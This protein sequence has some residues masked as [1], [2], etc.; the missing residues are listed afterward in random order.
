MATAQRHGA[1]FWGKHVKA[2]A[3]SG[4]G[5]T[6]YCAAQWLN[7][8]SFRCWARR[9]KGKDSLAALTLV[10]VSLQGPLGAPTVR[11]RSPGGWQI[12]L[13]WEDAA[14]LAWLRRQLP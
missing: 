12:E 5:P 6:A 8:K 11:L 7:D 3:G 1:E 14:Q 10:P 13:P 2:W 9:L 4:L